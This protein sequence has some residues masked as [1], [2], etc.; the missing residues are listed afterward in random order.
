MNTQLKR[1]IG[2]GLGGSR[3][4]EL[5]LLW[6]CWCVTAWKFSE[7]HPIRILQRLYVGQ[8]N[9]SL[10]F[11]PLSS[12]WGMEGGSGNSNLII[13]IWLS[14]DQEPS[15]SPPKVPSIEQKMLLVLLPLKN[16]QGLRSPVSE[17]RSKT[18]VRIKMPSVFSLLWIY[19]GFRSSVPAMEMRTK[20][21]YFL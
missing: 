21:I 9:Y 2:R 15:R 18:D 3:V 14:G 7:P 10:H 4:R 11:W 6:N 20:Y 5:L 17:M 19:K 1:H 13:T 8:I 16:L 12:L